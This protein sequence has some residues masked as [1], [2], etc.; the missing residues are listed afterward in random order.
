[1]FNWYE[2]ILFIYLFFLYD[3]VNRFFGIFP[4]LKRK[5]PHNVSLK[6]LNISI[7]TFIIR[8]V[9]ILIIGL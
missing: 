2:L 1:M 3:A 5:Q 7:S 9:L 4:K 8:V 6:N